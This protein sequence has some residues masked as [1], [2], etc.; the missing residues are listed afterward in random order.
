MA[1]F[2]AMTPP[3]GDPRGA[4][5]AVFVRDGFAW[6]AF[7]IPVFWLLWHRLWIEAAV[8]FAL[9]LGI[10]ALGEAFGAPT[11][12]LLVSLVL[13]WGVGL[14]G[15]NWRLARLRRQGFHEA[16]AVQ[17]HDLDEAETRFFAG[18]AEPAPMPAPAAPGP[19]ARPLG[20]PAPE[21]APAPLG[22]IGY[23]G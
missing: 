9:T 23:K 18:E 5:R 20:R 4:D 21:T 19:S 17:A 12:A 10:G 15:Q 1:S 13:Q 14:E 22:L 6:M 3:P 2:V 16:G 8:V 11:A 7:V